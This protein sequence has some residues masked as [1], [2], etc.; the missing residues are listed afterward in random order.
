MPGDGQLRTRVVRF[1]RDAEGE[2]HTVEEIADGTGLS[3]DEVN[4][5]L[6]HNLFVDNLKPNLY[7]GVV[8][9][10]E[11]RGETL[12]RFDRAQYLQNRSRW[13]DA[14]GRER[15]K[16]RGGDDLLSD[17]PSMPNPFRWFRRKGEK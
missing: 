13:I 12:Y 8:Q 4:R 15:R 6:S 10:R 9:K 3:V 2:E 1:L 7:Y 14:R 11:S 5:G 17:L 16:G